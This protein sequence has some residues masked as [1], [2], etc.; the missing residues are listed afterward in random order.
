[1]SSHDKFMSRNPNNPVRS[2]RSRFKRVD[3]YN[4]VI[5]IVLK[6]ILIIKYNRIRNLTESSKNYSDI[7]FFL[8]AKS[9][10][11]F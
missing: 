10:F 6:L 7:Y 4:V 11:L 9:L 5:V 1:M 3:L 8:A 2:V